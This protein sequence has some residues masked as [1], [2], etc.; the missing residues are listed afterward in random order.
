MSE[1]ELEQ[2]LAAIDLVEQWLDEIED[3]LAEEDD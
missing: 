1:Q 3:E 2:L